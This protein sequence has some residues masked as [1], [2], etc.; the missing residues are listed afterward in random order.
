M[1]SELP[2]LF[3]ISCYCDYTVRNETICSY[4]ENYIDF[5][6][7]SLFLMGRGNVVFI[8]RVESRYGALVL[9]AYNRLVFP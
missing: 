2:T 4:S 9:E 5:V 3:S 8:L 6:F 7:S 1:C